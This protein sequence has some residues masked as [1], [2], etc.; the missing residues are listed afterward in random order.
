MRMSLD[1]CVLRPPLPRPMFLRLKATLELNACFTSRRTAA[2]GRAAKANIERT[3]R[4]LTFL[5]KT[6]YIS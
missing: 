4:L 6:I 5:F 2:A 3:K 1:A